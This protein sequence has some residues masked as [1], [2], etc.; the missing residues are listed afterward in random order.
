MKHNTLNHDINL[1]PLAAPGEPPAL[2][3]Y[4]QFL[5][6]CNGNRPSL[7]H[8]ANKKRP[9]SRTLVGAI[10][11]FALNR[12]QKIEHSRISSQLKSTNSPLRVS[13][14]WSWR[15]KRCH[16][17]P[18]CNVLPGATGYED[19]HHLHPV[20]WSNQ[21]R[22]WESLCSPHHNIP[23]ASCSYLSGGLCSSFF[24][25]FIF[26]PNKV[27][28]VLGASQASVFFLTTSCF[29][30]LFFCFSPK[31]RVFFLGC[32]TSFFPKRKNHAKVAFRA[33]K[34]KKKTFRS[35]VTDATA[36]SGP[37]DTKLRHP[38]CT[39]IL[40]CT[41]LQTLRGDR[42]TLAHSSSCTAKCWP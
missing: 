6:L 4:H 2:I 13:S 18:R 17:W 42:T 11:L 5:W 32:S 9:W 40:G 26:A 25:G 27:F 7:S 15:P 28:F 24:F 22:L 12:S 23:R 37:R 33:R 36:A 20:L 31:E 35:K 30:Q 19:H 1:E 14:Y 21:D 41:C 10:K 29:S 39:G 8:S 38:W 16:R 34:A 3:A